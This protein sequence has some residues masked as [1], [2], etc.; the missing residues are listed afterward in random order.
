MSE[1]CVLYVV[2]RGGGA[3][4]CR[5]ASL[6][7]CKMTD[8][9]ANLTI[10]RYRAT[11]G[12]FVVLCVIISLAE[13]M[14]TN[15]KTTLIRYKGPS[16]RSEYFCVRNCEADEVLKHSDLSDKLKLGNSTLVVLI[17]RST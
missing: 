11:V 5:D 13:V 9:A 6:R 17:S 2:N 10:S 16:V 14:R 4:R 12:Y 3:L 1:C 15:Q 7:R 8:D